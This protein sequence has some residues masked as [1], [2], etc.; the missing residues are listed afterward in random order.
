MA[1]RNYDEPRRGRDRRDDYDY[2]YRREDEYAEDDYDRDEAEYEE[3]AEEEYVDEE[4]ADEYAEE[5][6]AEEYAEEEYPEDEYA[7]EEL[8]DEE[9]ADEYAEEYAE[10]EYPEDEYADEEPADEEYPE[11]YPEDDYDRRRAP[12]RE[13]AP[14]H[15]REYARERE[16]APERKHAPAQPREKRGIRP[17]DLVNCAAGLV[18][19][20]LLV[21]VGVRY[22]QNRGL[23]D[24]V[25]SFADVGKQLGDLDLVGT[26]GLE[27]IANKLL[28]DERA[29]EELA[30][31]TPAPTEK[32]PYK[33]KEIEKTVTVAIDTTSVQKDLKIK[34]IN[35]KT[36]KLIANVPFSIA[37][38]KPDGKS[39]TWT[40]DD[41]DGIIY[42][43]GITPGKY[44]ITL[45]ELSES[46]A[47]YQLPGSSKTV[48]V[49]K[50]IA[51]KKVDVASEIK[52]ESEV[53]AA[54]EDTKKNETTVESTLKD[55]VEWVESTSVANS[56]TEVL[57]STIPDPAKAIAAQDAKKTAYKSSLSDST[58]KL[59]VNGTY[60]LT[61]KC[62]DD[63][64]NDVEGEY[65][66]KTS[67]SKIV[68]VDGDGGKA[69]IK[70]LA[71]G[72]AMISFEMKVKKSE[73]VSGSDAGTS[74]EEVLSGTC[75]VTVTAEELV[76]GTLTADPSDVEIAVGAEKK[77]QLTATGFKAEKEKMSSLTVADD[78]IAS[79]SLD[80]TDG[81]LTIKGLAAGSTT[82]TVTV[83][84]K[85][86]TEKTEAK[87]VINVKVTGKKAISLE[88][89]TATVY[90]GTPL[91]LKAT[92]T[93]TGS[94]AVV[95]AETADANIA[96]A[97]ANGTEITVTGIKEGTVTLMLKCIDGADELKTTCALTVKK[98]AKDDKT[99]K[100]KDEKNNQ[101]Y[102]YENNT[103]RE[104]VYADYYTAEK[105]F[106]KGAMKYTG[107]Q[108][109]DGK[110]YYFTSTGAK[111][112]GDQ[113]IQGARYTFNDEG[114]LVSGNG[115]LG[116]DVSKWNGD[117]DWKA[118][119]NA[120]VNYA[121]IRCGYRGSTQGALIEDSK[122]AANMKGAQD[123]GIKVG[124][125]FYTQAVNE[126]E[127]VYEAS[128]VL[129][130]I[131]GYKLSF[132]VF[133]DVEPS[134][135]RGDKID[136]D[137][138]T[139]V[140]KAFCQTIQNEGYTAG[141]Y[142]NKT[143]FSE[144]IDAGQLGSYKIWLAQ[145][146]SSVSY[147][148]RYDIWQYKSTGRINGIKGDVD[149]NLSYLGY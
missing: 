124:V 54:K 53:N 95:L 105:F 65:T 80:E 77:V 144:K 19:I 35:Q 137:T 111:V 7:E 149:L 143:W 146:A 24:Q 61:A 47:T 126:V 78:K 21:F 91:V 130:K 108:T 74:G 66:W 57:K 97:K 87:T 9:Y 14:V 39:D 96:T 116:I 41:K 28:E 106:V 86:G 121:I 42:K 29:A 135:G 33:E 30:K 125:Y 46:Y 43:S 73:D 32:E 147:T 75:S 3:Y 134:G 114:Y 62:V 8:A 25:S 82:V 58:V 140:C 85:D 34:M 11:E 51:Y 113:V 36:G 49:L 26:Q 100:L 20:A 88:K 136:K 103:Y 52:K 18:V 81:K 1:G 60:E 37:V 63:D 50:D 45:N 101:I 70:G 31:V 17:M 145:Y 123:A 44:K 90:I 94:T 38:V 10:E 4:Y 13:Y 27:N 22:F 68:S 98:G 99:T 141:V 131:R 71:A 93:N 92:L 148:G 119:K 2:R 6:L 104:A 84:Y 122:F 133:L 127:A 109:I 112:T 132:P 115:S 12:E 102:V 67:D 59:T 107:W 48:E 72:T 139:A 83:N 56:Y 142:A 120:G 69:K 64:G 128:F 16:Y 76:A 118:V 40:D 5:E 15:E 23:N 138:R 110:V 117:I 89:D 55:T 129:E 79:V